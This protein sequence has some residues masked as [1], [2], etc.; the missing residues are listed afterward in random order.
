MREKFSLS[1]KDW[2]KKKKSR[3]EFLSKSIDLESFK[4]KENYIPAS[5]PGNGRLDLFNSNMIVT[6]YLGWYWWG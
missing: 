5:V 1:G 6:H 2:F 4:R 3:Q